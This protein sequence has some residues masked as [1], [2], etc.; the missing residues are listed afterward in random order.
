MSDDHPGADQTPDQTPARRTW[1]N[2]RVLFG[3]WVIG[4]TLVVVPM[5]FSATTTVG[6][7]TVQVAV[8]PALSGRTDLSLPPLGSVSAAT[9]AAPVALRAELRE[10]DVVEAIAAQGDPDVVTAGDPL[11]AIEAA[12]REDLGAAVRDLVVVL[13]GVSAGAGLL[14]AATFPGSRSPRRLAVAAAMAPLVT[15]LLVAPALVGYDADA[16][17]RSPTFSGQL[18]SAEELLTRVGSLETRFGSVESRTRVLSAR[19]AELYSATLTEEIGRSSGDVVVLHVSDLHLNTVGLALARDLATSFDVDAVLDTGDIT[20]F[21]FEPEA[22]FIDLLAGFDVPYLLVAG[23]HDSEEV[24]ARLAASDDVVYLDGDVAEV[25]GVRI[26]GVA[27]PTVT[28]LRSVP[29]AQLDRQYRAQY[30][31]IEGL[32]E[33]E[34][35][36]LLAVHNPVQSRPVL[37]SVPAVAAGHLHRSATEVV[38]GTVVAVVGSSGAT[39]IG[40]LLVD[41]D[42]PYRFQL[43]RFSAGRLVAID[44][45]TLVGTNGDFQLDRVLLERDDP[46]RDSSELTTESVEE[47]ARDAVGDDVLDQVTSTIGLTTTSTTTTSTTTTTTPPDGERDGDGP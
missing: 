15:T 25:D 42:E 1:R 39:G 19:L 23:N 21:G 38:D 17:A 40:N 27:D 2:S 35:P 30:G 36:D 7:G 37:G 4:I 45:L 16:F 28:A 12:V 9:H 41:S 33:S 24:R 44:Q 5:V 14:A 47:P 6:P 18:G 13:I 43:L 34:Q 3:A 26:L 11:P 8:A 20:S 31:L 29:E 46:G 32:V 10:V 22:A